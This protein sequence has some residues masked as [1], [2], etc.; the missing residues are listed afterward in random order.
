MKKHLLIT[1]FIGLFFGQVNAQVQA[2]ADTSLEASGVGGSDWTSTSTNFG[3]A[4]CSVASCGTCS[5]PCVPRS[6][7]WYVWF[8]GAGVA[9]MGTLSQSFTLANAGNSALSFWLKIPN[10][11]DV[12]DSVAMSIDGTTKWYKLG[13]D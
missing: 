12:A 6:G 11:G 1:L 9:E 8:G 3:T 13:N 2:L 10:A 4:F 7:T 5:G